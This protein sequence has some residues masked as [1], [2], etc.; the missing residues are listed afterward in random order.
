[1]GPLLAANKNRWIFPGSLLPVDD[2]PCFGS[3]KPVEDDT[4]ITAIIFDRNNRVN[5]VTVAFLRMKIDAY[6]QTVFFNLNL[7]N[8]FCQ[9]L[10]AC[11]F[12]SIKLR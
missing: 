7:V 9:W 12:Q 10:V 3:V 4:Y 8:R 5:I 6:V 11:G 2:L 1:M